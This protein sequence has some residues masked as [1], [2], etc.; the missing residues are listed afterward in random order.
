MFRSGL[1][2]GQLGLVVASYARHHK[3][4]NL[5]FPGRAPVCVCVCTHVCMYV[6]V[7]VYMYMSLTITGSWARRTSSV[8]IFLSSCILWRAFCKK[9]ILQKLL[10]ACA[11]VLSVEAFRVSE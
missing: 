9:K 8:S 5:E 3:L 7:C 1:P 6:G 2:F 11:C 4:P 10:S